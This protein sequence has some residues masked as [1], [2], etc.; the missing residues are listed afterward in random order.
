MCTHTHTTSMRNRKL[1]SRM[2]GDR[3]CSGTLSHSSAGPGHTTLSHKTQIH[4]DNNKCEHS[5]VFV[6]S[7]RA[8][9]R[10]CACVYACMYG[11]QQCSALVFC[12]RLRFNSHL[13]A[14][15]LIR[16]KSTLSSSSSSP[17]C[18][19]EQM[20]TVSVSSCAYNFICAI[21]IAD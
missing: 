7:A 21:L 17:S 19:L 3:R 13:D 5:A 10:V 11:E 9:A 14:A 1:S 8:R 20:R 18:T 16:V 2:R 12:V 6:R 15:A 4:Y